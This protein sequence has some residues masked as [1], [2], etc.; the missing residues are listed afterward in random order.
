ML[1]GESDEVLFVM[2]TLDWSEI[3]VRNPSTS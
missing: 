2:L 1:A 3:F